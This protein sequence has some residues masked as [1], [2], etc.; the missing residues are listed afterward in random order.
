MS[1]C[2]CVLSLSYIPPFSIPRMLY[3]EYSLCAWCVFIKSSRVVENEMKNLL[4]SLSALTARNILTLW[5]IH[6]ISDFIVV[7][8]SEVSFVIGKVL[9]LADTHMHRLPLVFFQR[10]LCYGWCCAPSFVILSC[11]SQYLSATK[12]IK[13]ETK[14]C[15]A[16]LSVIVWK[17]GWNLHGPIG[18]EC[19]GP[20][21]YNAIY[22]TQQLNCNQRMCRPVL[23]DP[24]VL[25]SWQ[26]QAWPLILL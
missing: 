12:A 9:S 17:D 7:K 1:V 25:S 2:L 11:N 20:D 8:L 10:L 26:Q 5:C 19:V 13:K 22:V 3:C 24:I 4:S 21:W 23:P 16:L 6:R 14:N 15:I 18:N